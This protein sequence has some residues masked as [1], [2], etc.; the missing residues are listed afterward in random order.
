MTGIAIVDYC[1]TEA[2]R[3]DRTMYYYYHYCNNNPLCKYQELFKPLRVLLSACV[4]AFSVG[5]GNKGN[6]ESST[7]P[8]DQYQYSPTQC[9]KQRKMMETACSPS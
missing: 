4:H 7:F 6:S 2:P 8:I 5:L 3:A 9:S 1:H